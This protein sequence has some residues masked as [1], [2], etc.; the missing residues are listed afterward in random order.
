MPS[1][2]EV[3]RHFIPKWPHGKEPRGWDI[4]SISRRLLAEG[5][6]G[7]QTRLET[8]RLAITGDR[9]ILCMSGIAGELAKLMVKEEARGRMY[10]ASYRPPPSAHV[11]AQTVKSDAP[12][13]L[14]FNDAE[15]DL[16]E[17]DLAGDADAQ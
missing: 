11:Q 8:W 13:I 9:C 12:A 17:D 16:A 14:P 6:I 10:L 1:E 2:P 5:V 4:Y 7:P 15:D 3:Y